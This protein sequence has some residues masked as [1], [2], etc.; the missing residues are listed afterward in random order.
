MKELKDNPKIMDFINELI[1]QD[2]RM[3]AFPN[4]FE[5]RVDIEMSDGK[6]QEVTERIFLT[7]EE[8]QRYI[9]HNKHNLENPY[10]F[11]SHMPDKGLYPAFINEICRLVTGFNGV[12]DAHY[13][14][15][16]QKKKKSD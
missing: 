10:I 2:N 14:H 5:V 8:A 7:E 9:A 4:L 3:T 11:V 6:V 13:A 1:R 12:E 15:V 16:E